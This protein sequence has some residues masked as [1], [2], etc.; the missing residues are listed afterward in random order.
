VYAFHH[1]DASPSAPS[2][3]D[4][5]GIARYRWWLGHQ[6]TFCVWRLLSTSLTLL[7]EGEQPAVEIATA[8]TRMYDVYSVLLLYAGS[9]SPE[10]YGR[11]IRPEMAHADSAFSGRWARDYED[12]PRLL[13]AVRQA[14]PAALLSDLLTA[15]EANRVVHVAVAK[16]LVSGGPSLLRLSGRDRNDENTDRERDVFDAF[17]LVERT[18]VCRQAFTAKLVG[19]YTLV[20]N[21]LAERPLDN[22][23]TKPGLPR[24]HLD[25][26]TGFQRNAGAILR[27]FLALPQICDHGDGRVSQCEYGRHS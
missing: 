10:V 13:R 26:V 6:A 24:A 12:I 14:Q 19:L 17:F 18:E 9:C 23:C 7:A 1:A 11:V 25:T 4:P 27:R 2:L 22:S 21:D 20:L 3:A 5:D 15:C 8:A 16:R